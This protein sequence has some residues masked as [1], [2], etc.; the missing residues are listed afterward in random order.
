V[1][2]DCCFVFRHWC[3]WKWN[4]W[5]SVLRTWRWKEWALAESYWITWSQ[6]IAKSLSAY[7][8]PVMFS[9][10][11]LELSPTGSSKHRPVRRWR[12]PVGVQSDS[13]FSVRAKHDSRHR[14]VGRSAYIWAEQT[15]MLGKNW[16]VCVWRYWQTSCASHA[17]VWRCN[18]S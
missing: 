15:K 4:K 17:N 10:V 13:W 12:I 16:I 1:V 8:S 11:K 9:C 6:M 18:S 3:L 5:R 14:S 2:I 7:V